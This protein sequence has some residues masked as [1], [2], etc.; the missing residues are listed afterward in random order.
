MP[1]FFTNKEA[2][3]ENT[4]VLTG[5]N[6]HHILDVLRLKKGDRFTVCDGEGTDYICE[7]ERGEKGK[8][9][10]KITERRP[11]ES[12]PELKITLFQGVA[13]G[14]K[15]ELIIQ[16]CVE[17]GVCRIVPVITEFTVVKLDKKEEKKR[18]RWQKIAEGAAKQSGRGIIPS[19]ASPVSFN[20]AILA[21]Q[22]L[23]RAV[24][25]YEKELET[26]IKTVARTG[27]FKSLGIFIGPEGGFSEEEIVKAKNAGITPLTLGKR[28]LRTETAAMVASSI[29]LYEAED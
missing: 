8:V 21:A 19:V 18:E 12:E 26:S 20:E 25:P 22:K 15:F 28:I 9:L 27:G 29:F 10:A 3:S 24:I 17:I 16:K 7:L 5:E 13:K 23:D 2:L 11:C 4:A 14:E 1:K 6:A